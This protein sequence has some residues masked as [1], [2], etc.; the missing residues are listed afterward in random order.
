MDESSKPS[1]QTPQ[2]KNTTRKRTKAL[3]GE[4]KALPS[5]ENLSKLDT[6]GE[7]KVAAAAVAANDKLVKKPRCP[8]GQRR[9]KEGDCKDVVK[10][11]T[12]Q[13]EAKVELLLGDVIQING[14]EALHYINYIDEHQMDVINIGTSVPKTFRIQDEHFVPPDEIR[15]IALVYQNPLR[16]FVKQHHFAIHSWISIHFRDDAA[17]LNAKITD[18]Q[19]DM[20]QI[21]SQ[22]NDTYYFINFNYQGIPKTSNIESIRLLA[23]EPTQ[24]SL[25]N[26]APLAVPAES[27]VDAVP[28]QVAAPVVLESDDSVMLES[29]DSV[30]PDYGRKITFDKDENLGEF[31]LDVEADPISTTDV[32]QKVDAPSDTPSNA[33][34]FLGEFP[35]EIDKISYNRFGIGT[36][37]NDM[38]EA[39]LTKIPSAKRTAYAVNKIHKTITR[40]KQLREQVSLVDDDGVIYDV[41]RK[42]PLAKPLLNYLEKYQNKLPWLYLVSSNV[43][44]QLVDAKKWFEDN[45]EPPEFPVELD[46]EYLGSMQNLQEKRPG[47][48]WQ[49]LNLALT[50]F[51]NTPQDRTIHDMVNTFI[52]RPDGNANTFGC[53]VQKYITGQVMVVK[54]KNS[55]VVRADVVMEN[56]AISTHA[57]VTLPIHTVNYSRVVL[58]GTSILDRAQLA[59]HNVPGH[60]DYL[61]ALLAPKTQNRLLQTAFANIE[62]GNYYDNGPQQNALVSS[63]NPLVSSNNRYVYNVPK[64]FDNAAIYYKS[65][66]AQQADTTW[67]DYLQSVVPSNKV[68]LRNLFQDQRN[69]V[70]LQLPYKLSIMNIVQAL[71]P[72]L[73]YSNNITSDFMYYPKSNNTKIKENI[74][75]QYELEK[76]IQTY[77]RNLEKNQ[78]YYDSFREVLSNN[79]NNYNRHFTDSIAA[80]EKIVGQIYTDFYVKQ[81]LQLVEQNKYLLFSENVKHILLDMNDRILQQSETVHLQQLKKNDKCAI[82]HYATTKEMQANKEPPKDKNKKGGDNLKR[83]Q[84]KEKE[85]EEVA[86]A[87]VEL[88]FALDAVG[89]GPKKAAAAAKKKEEKENSP[90]LA[91]LL[92]NKVHD[93]DEAAEIDAAKLND[94]ISNFYTLKEKNDKAIIKGSKKGGMIFKVTNDKK[95]N[96]RTFQIICSSDAKKKDASCVSTTIKTNYIYYTESV[97]TE[98]RSNIKRIQ[99]EIIILKN[100][101]LFGYDTVERIHA[102]FLRLKKQL[103]E[104]LT[105]YINAL[106]YVSDN[107][108]HRKE[109]EESK[110]ELQKYVGLLDQETDAAK[111]V[112]NYM[113]NIHPISDKIRRLTY[114]INELNV[115]TESGQPARFSLKQKTCSDKM[116]EY[117]IHPTSARVQGMTSVAATSAAVTSAAATSAAVTS[118]APIMS[119]T[120]K[121]PK[122]TTKAITMKQPR[123]KKAVK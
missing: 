17:A 99:G 95:A 20:I 11:T 110:R 93:A 118:A 112:S 53:A 12:E 57:L 97:L 3:K 123:A 109:V 122:K 91:N 96:T 13:K 61:L 8:P 88:K 44:K 67:P 79:R 104:Y 92:D 115:E 100:N 69:S 101:A 4:V 102:S 18:I 82:E 48:M 72:F 86:D 98:L 81:S 41:A 111:I 22:V 28:T 27:D 37:V 52:A 51:Y 6:K 40:Y 36:Q 23:S 38:L 35:V 62:S 68:I 43:Q 19:D 90:I 116:Y 16:G 103:L 56:D 85:E 29:D 120:E 24:P 10:K 46:S 83:D 2:K 75:I 7:S 60:W 113:D 121:K 119:L 9:N 64:I 108:E 54:E 105:Q 63:N 55:R 106:Q 33:V 49:E 42:S 107:C 34:I 74:T 15:S 73:I 32:S 47:N 114:N 94:E 89:G 21:Y 77:R 30:M 71:E 66:A 65:D 76:Q 26:A 50:P 87:E 84:E 1:K 117:N 59:V 39:K 25:T 78:R 14:E 70:V 80:A 5:P 58:P 45:E 31:A